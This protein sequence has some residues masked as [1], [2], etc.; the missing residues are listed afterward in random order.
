[1]KGIRVALLLFLCVSTRLN[2]WTPPA[3]FTYR[4]AING[5]Y[6]SST[7]P[8]MSLGSAIGLDAGYK[9]HNFGFRMQDYGDI[10]IFAPSSYME[11]RGL[12]YGWSWTEQYV[13]CALTV[14]A[15]SFYYRYNRGTW[16]EYGDGA[17]GEI[18]LNG[19]VN[20]RG[21]GVGVRLAVN[22]NP[23]QTNISASIYAQLGWAWN[24]KK[25]KSN[26]E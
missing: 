6:A 19:L 18:A 12:Y 25:E 7:I 15:G 21:N 8:K 20:C 22:V 9:H 11:L 23:L 24:S 1:M 13:Q 5:G 14:G 3:Y 2:A 17:Y 16:L 10:S 4:V 26:S